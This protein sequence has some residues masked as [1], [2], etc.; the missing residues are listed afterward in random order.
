MRNLFLSVL[1]VATLLS[2]TSCGGSDGGENSSSP[3][4]GNFRFVYTTP[5]STQEV[6]VTINEK[7]LSTTDEGEPVYIGYVVND[8]RNLV[9][10]Y[11]SPSNNSYI[12]ASKQLP[13]EG[14]N[15]FKFNISGNGI[16][17]GLYY[18]RGY[19]WHTLPF[20]LDNASRRYE[21]EE[22]SSFAMSREEY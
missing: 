20:D 12:I 15:V 16:L 8:N 14:S 5:H 3:L 4:I 9:V 10:G 17:T 21:P 1:F 11:W 19:D 7:T 6:R 22:W 13:Y 18:E 2:I